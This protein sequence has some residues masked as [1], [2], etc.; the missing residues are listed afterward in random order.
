MEMR[1]IDMT[2]IAFVRDLDKAKWALFD[3][4][5]VP[6]L[7][8][9]KKG[10]NLQLALGNLV[11]PQEVAGFNDRAEERDWRRRAKSASDFYGTKVQDYDN[12]DIMNDDSHNEALEEAIQGATTIISCVGAVR[13]S[14]VWSDYV[15]FWRLF[16]RDASKWCRDAKHPYYV[17]YESTRKALDLAEQEQNKREEARRKRKQ[18]DEK[19]D[20]WEK[21]STE[22]AGIPDRIRFIR[23]SDL[24]LSRKPWMFIPV[25]TNMVQSMVFRYQDMTER[26]LEE[27]SVVDTIILRP[28]DLTDEERVRMNGHWVVATV[29]LD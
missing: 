4:L 23:I 10:P 12:R 8:P 19:K 27:S 21:S 5:L 1:H 13:P 26:L 6:R 11:P 16:S 24:I 28:G 29:C 9:R 15:C 20:A 17:H 18:E 22:D 3:D 25:L 2:V 7:G 14:N